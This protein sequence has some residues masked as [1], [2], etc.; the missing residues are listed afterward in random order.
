MLPVSMEQIWRDY[1][2]K[3][4]RL[5]L[6]KVG[7]RNT[8]EDLVSDIFLKISRNLE[9]FDPSKAALSTWIYTISNNTV[10]DWFR[11]NRITMQLPEDDGENG[12][13]PES[14]IDP[15]Q[16]ESMLLAEEQLELLA[17]AL[18]QLPERSRDLIILH[19][20]SNLTL[21]EVSQK[22]GMSYANA[23][24]VHKKALEQLM[25]YMNAD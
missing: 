6:R 23:K 14:L 20:Y 11:T 21:K 25:Q 19:Y 2:E 8:A 1:H 3:V 10:L 24:I 9:R 16:P 4:S 15:G 5:V 7:D 12:A 13:V 22:M 18:T 17:G